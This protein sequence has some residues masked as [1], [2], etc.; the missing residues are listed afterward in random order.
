MFESNE[1]RQLVPDGEPKEI[2]SLLKINGQ[3]FAL[4]LWGSRRVYVPYE[5]II[6]HYNKLFI[7]YIAKN[8]TF[9]KVKSTKTSNKN[10]IVNRCLF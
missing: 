9:V 8:A 10:K 7:K 3:S 1:R 5:F 2:L 4:V 6:K